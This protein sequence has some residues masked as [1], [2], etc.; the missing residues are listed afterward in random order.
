M[1][2]MLLTYHNTKDS[3]RLVTPCGVAGAPGIEIT[4]E[5]SEDRERDEL[6]E[7]AFWTWHALNAHALGSTLNQLIEF[8]CR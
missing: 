2:I 3:P 1:G 5:M 8:F 6:L 7:A 4:K